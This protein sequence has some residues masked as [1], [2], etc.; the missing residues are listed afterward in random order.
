MSRIE[1]LRSWMSLIRTFKSTV[2]GKTE[3][4]TKRIHNTIQFMCTQG[5][6]LCNLFLLY[7]LRSAMGY[8]TGSSD[9][10]VSERIDRQSASHY[11][12]RI[13]TTEMSVVRRNIMIYVYLVV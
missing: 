12:L 11:L 3:P 2:L 1:T 10:G 7:A 8:E 5:M 6:F 9:Y 13:K 4:T